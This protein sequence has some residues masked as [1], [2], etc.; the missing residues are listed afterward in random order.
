MTLKEA[1]RRAG[2]DILDPLLEAVEYLQQAVKSDP[3]YLP[4]KL[5]LVSAYLYL[6]KPDHAQ[7]ILAEA[8]ELAP[9]DLALKGLEALALYE[10][11]DEDSDLQAVAVTKL[12]K[13]SKLSDAPP[14]LIFSVARL[15]ERQGFSLD[16]KFYWD[17]L[18]TVADQVPEPIWH[19]A[20]DKRGFWQKFFSRTCDNSVKETQPLPW[21]WPLSEC[22]RGGITPTV[23]HLRL[24]GWRSID[25]DWAKPGL[26][27]RIYQHPK[28]NAEVLEV[29]GFAQMQV[30]K[31]PNLPAIGNLQSLC[32]HPL[33]RRT[34]ANGHI[35]SCT[36]WAALIVD[37]ELTE[38]WCGAQ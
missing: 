38:L 26:Y 28:D 16:A 2:R 19:L 36:D 34:L 29:D 1:A 7:A 10:R 27:G 18:A 12:Q 37:D 13:L 9:D 17:R 22:A 4:A 20:C 25:F 5:N 33:R 21:R 23:K 31:A 32:A 24:A 35:L 15:L 6:G 14:P 8:R 3:Q 11:S 30:L